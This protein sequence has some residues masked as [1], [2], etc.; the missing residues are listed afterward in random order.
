M[1]NDSQRM[2][3]TTIEIK[4][5]PR[6]RCENC[7]TRPAVVEVIREHRTLDLKPLPS[8]VGNYFRHEKLCQPCANEVVREESSFLDT[9]VDDGKPLF[10]QFQVCIAGDGYSYEECGCRACQDLLNDLA[11]LVEQS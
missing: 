10:L 2:S 6:K 8:H 3:R 4:F 5:I 11:N 7:R 1:T 9:V